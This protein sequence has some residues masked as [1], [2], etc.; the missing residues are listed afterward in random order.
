MAVPAGLPTPDRFKIMS[1]TYRV[2][3]NN[4]FAG[5][6]YAFTLLSAYEKAYKIYGTNIR[7]ELV[8]DTKLRNV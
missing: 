1:N 5:Y 3:L 4:K 7:I 8:E 2:F 6:V